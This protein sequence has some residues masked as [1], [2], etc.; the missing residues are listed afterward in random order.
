MLA[1]RCLVRGRAGN[2]KSNAFPL[3]IQR[4][5]YG[6]PASASPPS[7]SGAGALAPFISELDRMAPSFDIRGEDIQ[8]LKTPTE[9]YETLKVGGG[10]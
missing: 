2:C 1:R 10:Y 4:R 8:I 9:F 6:T 3:R 5:R 7:A